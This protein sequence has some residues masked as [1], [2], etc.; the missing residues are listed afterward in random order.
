MSLLTCIFDST[1]IFLGIL[2]SAG[3]LTV[4][5][6]GLVSWFFLFEQLMSGWIAA[7]H[8][9]GVWSCELGAVI[10]LVYEGAPTQPAQ[11]A[12]FGHPRADFEMRTSSSLFAFS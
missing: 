11:L 1:V 9:V 7:C 6:Q 10:A 8:I 3:D 5:L 4:V 12:P 2:D